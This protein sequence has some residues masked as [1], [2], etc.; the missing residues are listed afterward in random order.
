MRFFTYLWMGEE[1][2]NRRKNHPD[3]VLDFA[4]GSQFTE[5]GVAEDDYVYIWSFLRGQLYLLGRMQVAGIYTQPEVRRLHPKIAEKYTFWAV[6]HIAATPES[7]GATHFDL[8][9]PT[10][11]VAKL[12]FSGNLPAKKKD[13]PLKD[14]FEPQ[15]FRGVRRLMPTSASLLDEL[16]KQHRA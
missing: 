15:T 8:V 5:R 14:D 6:E 7:I 9:V 12:R 13:T 2:K 3:W 10:D 16:L 1:F 4:A 11:I